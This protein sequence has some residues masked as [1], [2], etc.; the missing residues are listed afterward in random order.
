MK[1]LV[2]CMPRSMTTWI[3]NVVRE[4]LADD[5]LETI[6]IDPNDDPAEILFA[7]SPWECPGQL[8]APARLSSDAGVRRNGR[9]DLVQM[10]AS[11]SLPRGWG[12]VLFIHRDA[13]FERACDKLDSIAPV[14]HANLCEQ[15]SGLGREYAAKEAEIRTLSTTLAQHRQRE[16]RLM[17]ESE[18]KTPSTHPRH[19]AGR[20]LA[21]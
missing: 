7:S 13:D 1:V 18:A 8:G 15:V 10:E 6:W 4:L 20:V 9:I 5:A 14:A 12:N 3:F 19:G 11:W 21:A 2:S 16:E 17:R